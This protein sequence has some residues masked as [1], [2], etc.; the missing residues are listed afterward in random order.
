MPKFLSDEEMQKLE[1]APQARPRII[2]DDEMAAMEAEPANAV[3]QPSLAPGKQAQLPAAAGTGARLDQVMAKSRQ[4]LSSIGQQ[5]DDIQAARQAGAANIAT[6]GYAPEIVGKGVEM[7][8]G[9]YKAARDATYR[10]T[11]AIKAKAPGNYLAGN[12]AAGLG[13]GAVA[14]PGALSVPA[15]AGFGGAQGFVTNPG[16]S[17]DG[18]SLQLKDRA[19]N[20]GIGMLLGGG[21]AL[22]AKGVSKGAQTARDI[23]LIKSGDMSRAAKDQIDDALVSLNEKQ[24]APRDQQLKELI[25][26]KQFS[27]N[28]DRVEGTFPRLAKVM[29]S[30]LGDGESRRALSPERA[31]RLKR[32]ADQSA[33]Y[34]QGKAFDPIATAKGEEAKSLADIMRGQ[35][36]AVPGVSKVNSEMSEMMALREALARPARSTPIAAIRA[37]P[38]TDKDSIIKTIDKLAGS[39]L[40]ALDER[41]GVARDLQLD[42]KNFVKP[43]EAMQELRKTLTRG[44]VESA[45]SLEKLP[46]GTREASLATVLEAKRRTK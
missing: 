23:G 30:K 19:V 15:A 42:P 8:G 26:G 45:Q 43:L 5:E 37:Q 22:A 38:G 18:D 3:R 21:S 33:N 39:K 40:D 4:D 24:I 9:D 6:L 14:S 25:K 36:N 46:A 11:A 31:L 41:I 32:A 28:P 17:E 29:K 35:I 34:A 10:D 44:A 2:S 27:V 1:S 12:A 7:L 13:L 16:K 20:A